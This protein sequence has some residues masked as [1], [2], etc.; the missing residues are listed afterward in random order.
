VDGRA[1]EVVDRVVSRPWWVVLTG[2]SAVCS[3]TV[4]IP[5]KILLS[6][7]AQTLS[8]PSGPNQAFGEGRW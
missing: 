1:L 5:T 7:S 6:E 8:H 4:A 3:P 2:R